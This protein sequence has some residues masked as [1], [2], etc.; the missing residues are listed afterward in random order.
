MAAVIVEH[1]IGLMVRY[2]LAMLIGF[3]LLGAVDTARIDAVLAGYD[4]PETPA[5][6]WRR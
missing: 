3:R 2:T 5:V 1:I 6:C 4:K